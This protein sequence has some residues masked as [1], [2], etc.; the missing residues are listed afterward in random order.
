[1]PSV[2]AESTLTW[3]NVFFFNFMIIIIF[4]IFLF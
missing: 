4:A 2:V 3:Y 1:M